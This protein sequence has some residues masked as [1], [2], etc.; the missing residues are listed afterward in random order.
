MLANKNGL[1]FFFVFSLN[2]EKQDIKPSHYK[3]E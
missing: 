3:Q 2:H 1:M